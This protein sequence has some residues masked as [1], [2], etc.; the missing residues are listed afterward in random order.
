VLACLLTRPWTGDL[1]QLLQDT[2]SW[3]FREC[4]VI[5]RIWQNIDQLL[6]DKN[7]LSSTLRWVAVGLS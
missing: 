3:H 5:T 6:I 4:H 7:T 1:V 2:W